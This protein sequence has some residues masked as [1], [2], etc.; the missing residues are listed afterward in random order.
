MFR[1]SLIVQ[2]W[3]G[4]EAWLG[5][6]PPAL[7]AVDITAKLGHPVL[8][9]FIRRTGWDAS[10][11]HLRIEMWGTQF[12]LRMTAQAKQALL[13]ARGGVVVRGLLV[14]EVPDSIAVEEELAAEDE[15][16]DRSEERRVGK[17][18][19]SR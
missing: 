17:E 13:H 18:C 1:Q 14:G 9:S 16:P 15:E 5:E 3:G 12:V 8:N 7:A 6:S 19:R 11:P 2:P 10:L 4:E